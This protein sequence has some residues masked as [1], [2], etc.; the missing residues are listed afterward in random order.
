MIGRIVLGLALACV[1]G[2]ASAQE[3]LHALQGEHQPAEH[4]QGR[5]RG[6]LHRCAVR[7]RH[8][9]CDAPREVAGADWAYIAHKVDGANRTPVEGWAALQYLQ[10][11]CCRWRTELRR[12]LQR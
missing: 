9:L 11:A 12:R 1:A 5:R 4:Q 2:A 10:P 8:R 7:R 3:Q 6:D